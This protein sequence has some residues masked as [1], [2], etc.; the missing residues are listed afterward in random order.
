[1]SLLK[2]ET[3]PPEL[4]LEIFEH[5]DE[6][7]YTALY[8][9]FQPPFAPR[10]VKNPYH[11]LVLVCKNWRN[12]A[13]SFLY[14]N[15]KLPI[16]DST[17]ARTHPEY[18]RW[19]RRMTLLTDSLS[20]A[21]IF[22]ICPNITVLLRRRPRRL[23]FDKS[24][25][26]PALSLKRLD[27]SIY[28]DDATGR[29]TPLWGVLSAAPNLEYLFLSMRGRGMQF[30]HDD[31]KAIHLPNLRTLRIGVS[32]LDLLRSVSLWSLPSLTTF[33]MDIPFVERGMSLIW[34][35]HGSRLQTVELADKFFPRYHSL[36]RCLQGCPALRELNYHLFMTDPPV[37]V[38]PSVTVVSLHIGPMDPK[39][40]VDQWEQLKQHFLALVEG[41]F[42]NLRTLNLHEIPKRMFADEGFASMVKPLIDRGCALEMLDG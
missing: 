39:S 19:V 32:N 22:G 16:S 10:D 3:L 5:L 1:M 11:A 7:S 26:S 38:Y 29:E 40:R 4:W 23:A 6:C 30:L 41:L 20:L 27:W 25:P 14:R 34:L 28:G 21:E 18:G 36:T 33:I 42:P 37:G 17:W 31:T 8:T 2:H 13:T 35:A 9:P 24:V 12:W 15:V